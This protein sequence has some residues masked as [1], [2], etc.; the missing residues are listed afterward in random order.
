MF[1]DDFLHLEK[2]QAETQTVGLVTMKLI[3][4]NLP[5]LLK[6]DLQFTI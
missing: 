2:S 3:C 5:L 1:I 6:I 4:L